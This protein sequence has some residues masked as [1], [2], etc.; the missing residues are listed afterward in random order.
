[1]GIQPGRIAYK[2]AIRRF[3]TSDPKPLVI[4]NMPFAESMEASI[5]D[6]DVEAGRLRAR[7]V[8]GTEFLQGAGVLQGGV[9]SAMLDL[10]MA[11]LSL[12]ILPAE[13]TCA[14]AQLNVHFLS[15]AFPGV[16]FA[17]SEMEK[18]GKRMLFNRAALHP[19]DGSGPAASATGVFTVLSAVVRERIPSGAALARADADV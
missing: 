3:E 18:C 16:F 19:A 4:R 2:S 1:M 14:T 11:F 12:A 7:F 8:C 5:V 17:E 9:L 10:S 15:P 6:L 13:F